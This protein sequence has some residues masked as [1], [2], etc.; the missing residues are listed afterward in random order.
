MAITIKE[1]LDA[2][3][4]L[5]PSGILATANCTFAATDYP[6]GGYPIT[7]IM[8]GFMGTTGLRGMT[9]LG[10]GGGTT[11]AYYWQYDQTTSKL[12]AFGAEAAATGTF[13]ELTE[14]PAGTDLS[15]LTVRV[16]AYGY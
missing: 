1:D 5:G 7:P 16:L 13:Y 4:N 2:R 6:T 10:V 14:A 3:Q 15:A 8:F 11:G 12:Q 9:V